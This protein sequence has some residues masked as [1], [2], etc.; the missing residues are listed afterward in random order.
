MP[1]LKEIVQFL[2]EIL[3]VSKIED[4]SM[5]GFQ[6]EGNPDVKKVALGVD[7]C[8]ELFEK[9]ESSGA[10]LIIVH[11]GLFWKEKDC[12]AVGIMANRLKY[13]LIHGISLYAAHLPL[14]VHPQIGNSAQ[15]SKAIGLKKAKPFG[16]YY[17]GNL[18]GIIGELEKESSLDASMSKIESVVGKLS[19]KDLFGKKIIKRIAIVSGGGV[20]LA[21]AVAEEG[22]DL[23]LTGETSHSAAM[24]MKELK[25]NTLYAGHYATETFG[26]VALGKALENRFKGLKTEFINC[27]TGL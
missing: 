6:V 17:G 11:H 23:F 27:P 18:V 5:N 13:L 16:K 10:N 20:S 2:D 8:M 14:D 19:R 22:A 3:N 26:V 7:A 12:R 1:Q 9:A 15:I 24:D 4:D 21:K 25:I